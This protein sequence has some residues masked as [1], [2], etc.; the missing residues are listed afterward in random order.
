[1]ERRWA[2]RSRAFCWHWHQETDRK[3]PGAALVVRIREEWPRR[4]RPRLLGCRPTE[5]K[6]RKDMELERPRLDL[7]QASVRAHRRRMAS[8]LLKVTTLTSML[9]SVALFI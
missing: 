6:P 5:R 8:E 9:E 3:K 2:D 1:M 4:S 7:A